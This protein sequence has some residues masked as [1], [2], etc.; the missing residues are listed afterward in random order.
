MLAN[1]LMVSVILLL[2]QVLSDLSLLQRVKI[3][4]LAALIPFCAGQLN[5]TCFV[6]ILEIA[7]ISSRHSAPRSQS[8]SYVCR[9]TANIKIELA[10]QIAPGDTAGHCFNV[11]DGL[12]CDLTVTNKGAATDAPSTV[13][14]PTILNQ[15]S[16]K[17]PAGGFGNFVG[18]PF[19]FQL[20]PNEGGCPVIP[21]GN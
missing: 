6:G 7:P 2:C 11:A 5:T 21:P 1:S 18:L 3:F 20:V 10:V 13:N 14:C 16:A 15:I 19:Q 12:R 9:A 17:C 4:A 8:I